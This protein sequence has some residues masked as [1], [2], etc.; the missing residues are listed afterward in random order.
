MQDYCYIRNYEV[1]MNKLYNFSEYKMACTVD[2]GTIFNEEMV[3]RYFKFNI[4]KDKDANEENVSTCTIFGCKHNYD[5]LAGHNL[6]APH[7]L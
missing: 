4:L 2:Y 3:K 1:C 6:Y 5:W 7:Q